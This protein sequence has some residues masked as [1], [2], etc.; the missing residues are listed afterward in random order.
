MIPRSLSEDLQAP[1]EIE[2]GRGRNR[3]KR[4]GGR[5]EREREGGRGGGK[6]SGGGHM[7]NSY[8]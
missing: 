2:G 3:G 1:G 4:R 5:R 7:V 6:E 8:M